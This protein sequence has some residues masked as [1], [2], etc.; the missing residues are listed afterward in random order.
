M[1]TNRFRTILID[2]ERIAVKRLER[3]LE[4]YHDIIEIIDTALNGQDGLNKINKLEPDLVF[5][6]IQMPELNGF[7]V[8]E[9]LTCKPIV[10]FVTAYDEYALKAFEV[11]SVD[12][13]LKPFSD[14]RLHDAIEK[15]RHL[16]KTKNKELNDNI[17]NLLNTI[18]QPYL[19]RLNIKI[20]DTVRLINISDI[21]FLKADNKY[22][23]VYTYD[24]KYLIT[25]SLSTLEKQLP[26]DFNRVH[27]SVIVNSNYIYEVF[28]LSKNVF[29]VR[30]KDK[31]QSSLP[32]SRNY[33]AKLGF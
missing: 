32:V 19:K 17:Q 5:L 21:Y 3:K 20:G 33:K 30:M 24:N 14:N 4:P 26:E 11:N 7:E 28:K 1:H 31:G 22:V 29:Q 13:L 23:E 16:T 6:D 8:L 27:R 15:L 12:Y 9:R 10:I 2:D 25:E 18:K